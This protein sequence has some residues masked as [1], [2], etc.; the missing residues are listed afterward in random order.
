[1]NLLFKGVDESQALAAD[2]L[3]EIGDHFHKPIF[4]F[5]Y[6]EVGVILDP[7][8]NLIGQTRHEELVPFRAAHPGNLE[9]RVIFL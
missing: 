1:M 5:V 7:R 2:P 6:A 4:D 8:V 3:V 9:V